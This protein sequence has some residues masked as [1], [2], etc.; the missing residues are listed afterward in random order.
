M[1]TLCVRFPFSS[2]WIY[3][4]KSKIVVARMTQKKDVLA[5]CEVVEEGNK[6]DSSA[7]RTKLRSVVVG[8]IGEATGASVMV[9]FVDFAAFAAVIAPIAIVVAS[10]V[11]SV[12]ATL[13]L[14]LGLLAV[15]MMPLLL[16]LGLLAVFMMPPLLPD[17]E[18]ILSNLELPTLGAVAAVVISGR[19]NTPPMMVAVVIASRMTNF[20]LSLLSV[21]SI[22]IRI[23]E[24]L[25]W[26]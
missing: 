10:A 6:D 21:G 7:T 19:A 3:Q 12:I 5:R 17:F 4:V 23:G 11:S 13:H 15:F 14:D 16:D 25:E 20:I 8:M 9:T 2:G 1:P 24:L 22:M 18:M 26:M